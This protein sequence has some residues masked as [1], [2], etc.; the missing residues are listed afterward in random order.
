MDTIYK[1]ILK[2]EKISYRQFARTIKGSYTF[3]SDVCN[4][5]RKPS[6]KWTARFLKTVNELKS[7]GKK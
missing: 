6:I 7:K 3:T 2:R 1:Q 5:K 4:G